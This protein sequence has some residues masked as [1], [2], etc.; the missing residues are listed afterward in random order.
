MLGSPAPPDFVWLSPN[1][2]D[3]MHNGSVSRVTPGSGANLAPV[4]ASRWLPAATATV[5]VTM[6]ENDPQSTPAGGIVPLVVISASATGL[7]REGAPG[8]PLRHATL[9]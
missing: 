9:D 5:I 3:D 7:G 4:L 6:D 8:K 2:G 1:L